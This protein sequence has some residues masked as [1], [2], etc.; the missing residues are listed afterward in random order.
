MA[1]YPVSKTCPECDGTN[2]R[3]VK[4][5]TRIAF[6]DDRVCRDC[7]SRYT[8]P[9]PLWA[10]LVFI[11]IGLG[12]VL[13]NIAALVVAVKV[14]DLWLDIRT[15]IF[16]MLT[17]STGIGCVLYGGR[18]VWKQDQKCS[19]NRERASETDGPHGTN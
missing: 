5:A 2:F 7:G 13:V 12:I 14:N 15:Y 9:T 10:A 4:P 16:L 3:R 1:M 11:A 8:P 18:C 19:E 6:T 17:L